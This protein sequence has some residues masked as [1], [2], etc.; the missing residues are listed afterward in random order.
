MEEM[1]LFL[2]PDILLKSREEVGPCF[3]PPN[4]LNNA[5]PRLYVSA[6]GIQ[7]VGHG[8]HLR[9]DPSNRDL[10]HFSHLE[11]PTLISRPIVQ[12]SKRGLRGGV[13]YANRGD[14]YKLRP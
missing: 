4:N 8:L 12:A 14:M 5:A 7:R 3:Q 11:G 1:M 10:H 2:D 9:R 6:A 13:S